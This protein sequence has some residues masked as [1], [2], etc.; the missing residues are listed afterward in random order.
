MSQRWSQHGLE[1]NL[2]DLWYTDQRSPVTDYL[3]AQGWTVSSRTR[4]Q[5]FADYGR[6]YP[7]GEA[8]DSFQ[9]SLSVTAIRG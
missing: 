9:N 6:S 2:S 5:V 3:A 7:S 4:P 8:G 1:L